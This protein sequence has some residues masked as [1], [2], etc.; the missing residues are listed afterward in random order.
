MSACINQ[1]VTYTDSSDNNVATWAWIFTGGTPATANT[2]G[3]HTIT[4]N[5]AGIKAA[6]LNI[7]VTGGQAQTYT[8]ANAT[9]ISNDTF[10]K[11]NFTYQNKANNIIAFTSTSTGSNKTYKW[12]FGDGDSSTLANPTHQFTNANNKSVKLIVKGTCNTDEI[13]IVLRDFTNIQTIQKEMVE[14]Y[15][16]PSNNEF[17][18]QISN[19]ETYKMIVFDVAG[20]T[21]AEKTVSNGSKID[22]SQWANGAYLVK[23]NNGEQSHTVRIMVQH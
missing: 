6:T 18:I 21:I 10:V 4:Y 12:Y 23:L 7:T 5:T 16:N 13:T 3:P 2:K 20:K 8:I 17:Q 14:F 11:A 1:P 9:T 19:T 22:C 15:P